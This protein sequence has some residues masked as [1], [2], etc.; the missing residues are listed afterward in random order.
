MESIIAI[1][2]NK[3]SYQELINHVYTW[4][5]TDKKKNPEESKIVLQF[6]MQSGDIHNIIKKF[7]KEKMI[8]YD[9]ITITRLSDGK[10]IHAYQNI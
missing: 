7:L 8:E 2:L 3:V 6:A 9:I 1:L 4:L 5:V 10:V